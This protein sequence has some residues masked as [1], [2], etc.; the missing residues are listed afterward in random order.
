MS[1]WQDLEK[2]SL[3]T[4]KNTNKKKKI[5]HFYYIEIKFLINES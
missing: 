1:L 3:K 5:D 4:I 2:I